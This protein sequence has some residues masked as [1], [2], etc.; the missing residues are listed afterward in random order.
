MQSPTRGRPRGPMSPRGERG[1]GRG[2][3]ARD[4]GDSIDGASLG[5]GE[6]PSGRGRGRGRGR[7]SR[8]ARGR[9]QRPGGDRP[10]ADGGDAAAGDAHEP[11]ADEG[12][13][14]GSS[15]GE[16]R[17]LSAV[18]ED[19]PDAED[20][21]E[22]VPAGPDSCAEADA[23]LAAPPEE[24]AGDGTNGAGDAGE[25]A[26]EAEEAV[27]PS[28]PSPAREIAAKAGSQP[29]Q[30]FAAAA[31]FAAADVAFDSAAAEEDSLAAAESPL[32]DDR[33]PSPNGKGVP[34]EGCVD[35]ALRK[36]AREEDAPEAAAREPRGPA[37]W[38]PASA[39][40]ST[41]V[42]GSDPDAAPSPKRA[43][44]SPVPALAPPAD[45]MDVVRE[46]EEVAAPQ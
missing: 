40:A 33:A 7:G 42:P 6:D 17:A 2:A 10:E 31:P 36:R 46:E 32:A 41:E 3:T 15:R 4:R 18:A 8:G 11:A 22:A 34:E 20:P 35:S 43:R 29:E 16:A 5:L 9:G 45:E 13:V 25:D 21:L 37:V 19:G 39:P 38:Y 12:L 23:Q 14:G 27:A 1:R 28:A 26:G 30:V 24:E 44:L